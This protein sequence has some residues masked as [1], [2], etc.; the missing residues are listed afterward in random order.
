MPDL[1]LRTTT[2]LCSTCKHAVPAELRRVGDTV[3]LRKRCP[4]HGEAEALVSSSAAWYE[5]AVASAP[6]LEA[7]GATG[8][9]SQ[10]CPFDC[11]PCGAHEQRTLLPIV[12]L[13]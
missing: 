3:V 13:T 11:G 7:P 2:S 6:V 12:P 4:E 5:D 9:V 1:L 10:G 8:P